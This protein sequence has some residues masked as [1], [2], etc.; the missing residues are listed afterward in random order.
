MLV[1]LSEIK[2]FLSI[3]FEDDDDLLLDFEVEAETYIYNI[4]KSN[5]YL[6]INNDLHNIAKILC[7]KIIFNMYENRNT[8]TTA[9]KNTE[10]DYSNYDNLFN[11]LILNKPDE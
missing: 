10:K 5:Y 9:Y 7:K 2:K 8:Y 6:D 1:S 4:V 11:L 3:D